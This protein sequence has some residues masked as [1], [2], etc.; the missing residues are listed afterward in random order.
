MSVEDGSG[1]HLVIVWPESEFRLFRSDGLAA[2]RQHT[3]AQHTFSVISFHQGAVNDDPDPF[4]S[5]HFGQAVNWLLKG[6]TVVLSDPAFE[7]PQRR[8]LV[9]RAFK[10]TFPKLTVEQLRVAD[11]AI[12]SDQVDVEHGITV[13]YEVYADGDMASNESIVVESQ[14][15]REVLVKALTRAAERMMNVGDDGREY[16]DVAALEVYTPNYVSD[17]TVDD[18]GNP[19]FYIDCKGGIE[20]P[21]AA[22]FREILVEE[23]TRAGISSAHVRVP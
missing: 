5:R 4:S 9:E 20:P 17:V 6:S 11:E 1:M 2:I 15:P 16:E 7:D 8:R 13:D 18:K 19:G 3:K 12:V 10:R 21:M 14:A 23:L 22:R